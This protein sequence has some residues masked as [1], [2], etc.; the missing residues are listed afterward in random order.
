MTSD[1]ETGRES[2]TIRENRCH[3]RVLLLNPPGDEVYIRDYY[4]SKVSKTDYLYHP[5]DLLYISGYLKNDFEVQVIDAIADR[6]S[7]ERCLKF[8]Q[9]GNF[10]AIVFL[11]GAVSWHD[12][13]RFLEKVRQFSPATMIGS[14]DIFLDPTA[15]F[16]ESTPFLDAVILDFFDP[17]LTRYLRGEREHL[18][19]FLFRDGPDRIAGLVSR[20][21]GTFEV[22]LPMPALFPQHRYKYPFAHRRRFATILTD[23]GCPHKCGFCV[24]NT[25]GF[26]QRS[27]ENV[28]AELRMYRTQGIR[29]VY[30]ADQT[31]GANRKR[32]FELCQSMLAEEMNLS[33]L[34]FSRVDLI[35]GESLDLM[36]KAGC[37]TI[38]FGVES[39]DQDIL[40]RYR[41]GITIAQVHDAFRLCHERGIATVGTFIIGLPGE[42]EASCQRT[43]QLAVDLGCDYASF[44]VPVPRYG[45]EFRRDAIEHGWASDRF[46]PM[47]QAYTYPVMGTEQLPREKI[48]RL[49]N[50]AILD[51]Y[52]RPAYLFRSLSRIRNFYQFE[53]HIRGML[54]MIR[55]MFK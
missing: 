16:F 18:S 28:M 24:M 30:F 25:L 7:P 41:K 49:R 34:C 4:C 40:D 26:K 12:D 45:T 47:C 14:G 10:D 17:S 48:W 23:Y 9:A 1:G 20:K 27:V 46:E 53:T 15:S 13:R 44:N 55:G 29:E 8:I 33:W 51:F 38:L 19:N 3:R 21:S 43:I 5:I 52:L 54:F 39:A 50:K 36:K 11:T 31:F 6:I 42:T 2:S 22:P 32:M 37:H 35:T